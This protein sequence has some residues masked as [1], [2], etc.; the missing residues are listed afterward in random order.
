MALLTARTPPGGGRAAIRDARGEGNTGRL[1]AL[2][3]VLA[4]LFAMHG[5]A[6]HGAHAGH[7][8]MASATSQ[9]VMGH[10][11]QSDA[12]SSGP[13]TVSATEQALDGQ[14]QIDRASLPGTNSGGLMA[15]CLAV[16]TG[17]LLAF[18][19]VRGPSTIALVVRPV[20]LGQARHAFADRDR[21]PPSLAAFSVQRC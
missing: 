11:Q 8:A 10:G 12:H 2:L 7:E 14:A 5:L 3:F 6:A 16:L 17:A 9:T 15:L 18:V 19:A 1:V 21:S 13:A 20:S 4:G